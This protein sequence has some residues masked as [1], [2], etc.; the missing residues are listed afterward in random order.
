VA[1]FRSAD[2]ICLVYSSL[3]TAKHWWANTFDCQ[4][5]E[6]PEY[7]DSPLPSD[8]ALRFR[9][10]E[11]PTITLSSRSEADSKNIKP[12]STVPIIYSDKLRKAHEHLV[13][14]GTLPG[15]IQTGGD[16]QFFEVRDPEGNTIEI[17]EEP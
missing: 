13:S 9:G 10:E 17:C 8:V 1:L 6:I 16:V 11:E 3:E 14:R 5:V 4:Q 2:P 12:M 7:W 15:D